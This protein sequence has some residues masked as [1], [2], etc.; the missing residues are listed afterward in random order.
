M[1]TVP[2]GCSLAKYSKESMRYDYPLRITAA[3]SNLANYSGSKHH[4]LAIEHL[5]AKRDSD[6]RIESRRAEDQRNIIPMPDAREHFLACE[7]EIEN[8]NERRLRGKF[9]ARHNAQHGG[10]NDHNDQG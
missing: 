2:R 1:H 4:A 7:R 10:H 9:Y 3:G 5:N 8:R 6:R